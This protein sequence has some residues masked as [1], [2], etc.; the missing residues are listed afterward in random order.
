MPAAQE[1][2]PKY[3]KCD[4]KPKEYFDR[5]EMNRAK[6]PLKDF[7]FIKFGNV[8]QM[9]V[10][11]W[12]TVYDAGPTLNQHWEHLIWFPSSA[13]KVDLCVWGHLVAGSRS[14]WMSAVIE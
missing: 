2:Y 11:C 7:N 12:A 8:E 3:K 1:K 10:Q 4:A 9:L 14:D 13:W 6:A 5:N